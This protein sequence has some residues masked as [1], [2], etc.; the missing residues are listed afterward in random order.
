MRLKFIIVIAQNRTEIVRSM[1][2]VQDAARIVCE[3]VQSSFL[4][5][6]SGKFRGCLSEVVKRALFRTLFLG[7]YF[8]ALPYRFL[9]FFNQQ[10]QPPEVFYEKLLRN[11]S[12]YSQENT[13]VGVSF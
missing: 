4:N 8:C 11:I 3:T 6:C 9:S 12:Q 5:G 1:Q 7:D 10:K 2:I 13:C